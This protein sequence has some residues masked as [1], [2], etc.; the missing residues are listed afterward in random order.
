MPSHFGWPS[1]FV[2]IRCDCGTDFAWNT[3]REIKPNCP[4]CGKFVQDSSKVEN[5]LPLAR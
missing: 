5:A 4:L 1:G 3:S 2:L